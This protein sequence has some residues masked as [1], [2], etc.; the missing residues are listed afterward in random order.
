[1]PILLALILALACT[2]PPPDP[3]PARA[4]LQAALASGVVEDVSKTARA[5]DVLRG[6]DAELDRLLGEALANVLMRPLDGLV[7]LEARPA[8]DDEHWRG[9]LQDALLRAGDRSRLASWRARLGLAE[10]DLDHPVYDQVRARALRDPSVGVAALEEG[11]SRCHLVDDAPSLGR[12]T[13]DLPMPQ[14]MVEAGL[15]LGA[16]RVVLARTPGKMVAA[17]NHNGGALSCRS[18]VLVEGTR[19]GEPF[20]PKTAVFALEQGENR[21]WVEAHMADAGPWIFGTDDA[22]RAGRWVGAAMALDTLVEGGSSEAD[23]IARVRQ[24]HPA[25][26]TASPGV[27]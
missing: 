5:A 25:L 4:A 16:E 13:L 14:R 20:P 24:D 22:A 21:L 3:A 10:L 8:P 19:F 23:A 15:A 26:F 27:P 18:R 1:M 17:S 12:Q 2:P 7:L 6:Q 9:A 11:L